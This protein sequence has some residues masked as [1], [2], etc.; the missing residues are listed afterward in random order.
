V[1]EFA[2]SAIKNYKQEFPLM[3]CCLVVEMIVEKDVMEDIRQ[4]HGL[5][6]RIQ[7]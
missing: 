3:I 1:T 4:Q 6:L 2:S 7:A 5:I